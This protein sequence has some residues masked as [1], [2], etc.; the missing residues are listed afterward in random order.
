[1]SADIGIVSG[2]N[3]GLSL[4]CLHELVD[5]DVVGMFW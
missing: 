5:C 4:G 1:M 3:V 2:D